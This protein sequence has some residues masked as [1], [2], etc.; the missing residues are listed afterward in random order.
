MSHATLRLF[1]LLCLTA[2]G[3]ISALAHPAPPPPAPTVWLT[4]LGESERADGSWSGVD[5]LSGAD[6]RGGRLPGGRPAE[7]HSSARASASHARVR[8]N[9]G[10]GTA[11][12]PH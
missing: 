2:I 8:P 4:V 5:V 3:A 1:Q 6:R 7:P 12:P 11:V 10:R 9:D